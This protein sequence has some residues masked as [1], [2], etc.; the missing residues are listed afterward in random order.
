VSAAA[1]ECL[2]EFLRK[3]WASNN[4]STAPSQ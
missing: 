3:D 4:T 2:Q 1:T